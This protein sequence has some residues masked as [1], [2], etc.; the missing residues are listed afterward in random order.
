MARFFLKKITISN[1]RIAN[2]LHVEVSH[3]VPVWY[4]SI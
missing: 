2:V 1:Q 3:R 4:T